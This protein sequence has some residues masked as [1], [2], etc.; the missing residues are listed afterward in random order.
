MKR[1]FVDII[2]ILGIIIVLAVVAFAVYTLFIDRP[3]YE[4]S[5][6][7]DRDRSIENGEESGT[8]TADKPVSEIEIKNISGRIETEKWN[9]DRVQLEYIKHGPGRHPEVK[10]DLTGNR[11]N[12][13]AVYPKSA[14]NFGSVDFL[15]K[16]PD[17]IEYFQAGTVSG[18]ID[19][20]GMSQNC[21][22]KLSSTSG[23][24]KTGS[25]GD[26][27][28]SSV[29]GSLSFSSAGEQI[30]ASTTSGKISGIIE[31][32]SAASDIKLRSVSG[33]ITLEVP[34]EINAGV[35]LHSVSG[36]VSSK[37]PVAVTETRR[38]SIK[39]VIGNG[40]ANIEINTVSGAIKIID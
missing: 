25:S 33:S 19:I 14:G 16:I 39:G 4:F 9:G 12:I 21:K 11:L 13:A 17:G 37:I 3:F 10:V 34:S 23:S 2:N 31:K 38:N 36:S 29:S 28:I 40:G 30:S 35:D 1:S 7:G 27:E 22:L 6:Y 8:Y 24:V 15:V 18:A 32:T 20:S 5:S 26:I